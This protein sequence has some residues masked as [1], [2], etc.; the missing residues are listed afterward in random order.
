MRNFSNSRGNTASVIAPLS[1]LRKRHVG[2]LTVLLVA[3]ASGIFGVHY[4]RAKAL[5]VAVLTRGDPTM[6]ARAKPYVD[7]L[8]RR[9]FRKTI[10]LKK[11]ERAAKAAG[12]NA[13]ARAFRTFWRAI[14]GGLAITAAAGAM[15]HKSP[16]RALQTSNENWAA[17]VAR[18][19]VRVGAERA[20]TN[21]E[22]ER[23]YRNL[24]AEL[25]KS[26]REKALQEAIAQK[27]ANNL[28]WHVLGSS[29]LPAPEK[30]MKTL[31]QSEEILRRSAE[32]LQRH[33]NALDP[34]PSPFAE[35]I[36]RLRLA[37]RS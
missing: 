7:A 19:A 11:L 21:M 26:K 16:R 18:E 10:D 12:P 24:Y 4:K 34:S 20:D 35:T 14:A 33:A 23:A 25:R 8:W 15:G 2:V 29:V 27:H 1:E 31:Q 32:T 6:T 3:I 37:T 13:F 30:H 17:Y 36:D 5:A 28:N 22:H 9:L